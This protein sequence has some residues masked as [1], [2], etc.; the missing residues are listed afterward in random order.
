MSSRIRCTGPKI[1]GRKLKTAGAWLVQGNE[2]AE[3][4]ANALIKEAEK[5]YVAAVAF[6]LPAHALL[7]FH[8][9]SFLCVLCVSLR[10]VLVFAFAPHM[11]S[12]LH[13]SMRRLCL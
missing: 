7:L 3:A 5:A 9:L 10:N 13:A 4:E 8:T 2:M 1:N 12:C 11:C 6:T